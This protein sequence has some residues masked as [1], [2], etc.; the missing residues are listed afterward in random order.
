MLNFL[1]YRR[2][3][4]FPKIVVSAFAG[5]VLCLCHDLSFLLT[6]SRFW[7]F[8]NCCSVI[9][10]VGGRKYIRL[11]ILIV[12]LCRVGHEDQKLDLLYFES[13]VDGP[14]KFNLFVKF[15][16]SINGKGSFLCGCC[17]I[18][19]CWILLFIQCEYGD[20]LNVDVPS[21]STS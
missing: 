12:K 10:S 7:Y 2:S 11:L 17:F 6:G 13:F 4:L 21:K 20:G 16:F 18:F 15:S 8:C 3:V 9:F 19:F 5:F 14:D 1:K